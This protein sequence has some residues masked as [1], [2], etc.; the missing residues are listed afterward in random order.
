[1]KKYLYLSIAVLLAFSI[2]L[3]VFHFGDLPNRHNNG[4]N[5][6]YFAASY[7]KAHQMDL[8][9][10]LYEIVGSTRSNIYVTTSTEGEVL[11]IGKD[12]HR[13]VKRIKIP[14]FSRYYDSLKFSSVAV[15]I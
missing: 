10:T 4:F 3:I 15:K 2:I 9:D 13:K 12:L 1:M 6:N 7:S 5:R 11:E 14:F 8:Q